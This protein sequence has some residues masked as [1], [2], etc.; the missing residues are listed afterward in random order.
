M[1]Y[2]QWSVTASVISSASVGHGTHELASWPFVMTYECVGRTKL[3]IIRP[4]F[5]LVKVSKPYL[6]P[7]QGNP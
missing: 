1:I 3:F 4:Q 7:G 2:I 6:T 5:V